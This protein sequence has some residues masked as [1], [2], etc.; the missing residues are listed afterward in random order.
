M[1]SLTGIFKPLSDLGKFWQEKANAKVFRWNIFF[2][3]SQIGFLFWKFNSLPPQIPLY[4]SLPWGQSQLAP[5]SSLFILPTISLV[6]LLINHLFA[7]SLTKTSALLSRL[8][9]VISLIF[10]LL[11]LITIFQIVNIIA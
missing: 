11:S 3:I 7:I 10:S 6:L 8:L 5:A 2:I 4:Y 1:S 9:V